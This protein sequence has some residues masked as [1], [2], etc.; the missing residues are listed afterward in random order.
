MHVSGTVNDEGNFSDS[1]KKPVVFRRRCVWLSE[2]GFSG[3]YIVEVG[4]ADIVVEGALVIW[5]LAR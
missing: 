2:A 5:L 4:I 3:M 1:Q